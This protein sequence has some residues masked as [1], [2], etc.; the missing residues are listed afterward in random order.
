VSELDLDG[1]LGD[2][3]AGLQQLAGV[4]MHATGMKPVGPL[5]VRSQRVRPSV[6]SA[7][8]LDAQ[9]RVLPETVPRPL[10]AELPPH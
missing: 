6:T 3:D 7:V 8:D 10:P 5:W 9:A 4:T 2:V 1:A